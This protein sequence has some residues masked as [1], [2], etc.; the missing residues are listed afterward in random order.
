[1][2]S[3]FFSLIKNLI[4]KNICEV[5]PVQKHEVKPVS[6]WNCTKTKVTCERNV[7]CTKK[8]IKQNNERISRSN[9]LY[10]IFVKNQQ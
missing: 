9:A 5:K 4:Q 1:M 6:R 7:F 3:Y 10:L 2:G 8:Q